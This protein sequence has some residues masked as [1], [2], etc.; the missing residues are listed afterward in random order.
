MAG[1]DPTALRDAL[2]G[3]Q[4]AFAQAARR[5]VALIRDVARLDVGDADAPALRVLVE[6]LV[7]REAADADDTLPLPER[8]ARTSAEEAAADAARARLAAHPEAGAL[9]DAVAATWD[10]A[11]ARSD[12]AAGRLP[13]RV[14]PE[15]AAAF[16][17]YVSALRALHER[18]PG[19]AER[20]AAAQHELNRAAGFTG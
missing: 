15:V 8:V 19:A 16:A 7:R 5:R 6:A 17:A 9:T 18:A 11:L 12:V 13:G 2:Q 20:Y 14:A 1:H 10:E 4:E 3:V